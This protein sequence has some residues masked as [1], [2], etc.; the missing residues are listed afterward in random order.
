M[1]KKDS[2]GE[3]PNTKGVTIIADMSITF[4]IGHGEEAGIP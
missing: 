3:G 1:L 4:K 2:G